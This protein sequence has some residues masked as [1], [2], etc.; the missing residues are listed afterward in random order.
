[1][2]RVLLLLLGASLTPDVARSQAPVAADSAVADTLADTLAVADTLTPGSPLPVVVLRDSAARALDSAAFAAITDTAHDVPSADL[3]GTPVRLLGRVVF[4]IYGGIGALG[5]DERAR[6]LGERLDV[7]ARN[8]AF[9]PDS[10]RLLSGDA[11]TTIQFG[12]L[13]VMSVTDADAEAQGLTRAQAAAYYAGRIRAEIDRVRER[14]TFRSVARNAVVAVALIGLLV[15]VLAGLARLFRWIDLR[16][17]RLYRQHLPAVA[18]RGI[19]VV[20]GDQIVRFG[21]ALLGLLRFVLTLL[22]V[23][24]TVTTVL[25]LFPWTQSWSRTLLAYLVSPVRAFLGAVVGGLPELFAILVIVFLVRM[26]VKGVTWVFN[27][28][29]EGALTLPGFYPE[30]ADPTRKIARF[31]LVLLGIFLAYPYTPI[32]D[33]RVFQGL[34]VFL[35]L[36]FSLGSSSAIANVVAGTL[37]TYTRAFRVG[38]RIRVGDNTGDVI[39]KTFLVTRLR[40]PKN[41][42]VS[43]PNAVVLNAQIVNYSAM[44]REGPGVIVHTTVTIGYD[45]PWATVHGL[46]EEAARRTEG[47]EADPAPFVLQTS[48]GDFSVAYQVNAYTRQ[49]SRLPAVLSDL[50]R[51]TQDVFAEAQIEI[52]SPVYEAHRDGNPSTLP[53]LTSATGSA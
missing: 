43:V 26:A 24:L 25:G 50:H 4:R 21:R 8:A 31:M 47:V 41:E 23:Y 44:A 48:L 35:G 15:F 42:D 3:G 20:R 9:D 29:E 53:R 16:F 28:V 13:I 39:E 7:L 14:S 19:E 12:S 33:S 51:H 30:F 2:M 52:L 18:V 27:R 11:L 32:A 37:L 34:T 36:L 17:L 10:L 46:L 45:V 5:A 22:L 1:M 6:R 38:D 40:T 49:A